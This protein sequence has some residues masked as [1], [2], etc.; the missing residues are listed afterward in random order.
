MTW[1]S[2]GV[3]CLPHEN[4][5]LVDSTPEHTVGVCKTVELRGTLAKCSL[6]SRVGNCAVAFSGHGNKVSNRDN[7][8]PSS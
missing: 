1:P 6:P 8:Q 2:H 7:P 3:G 4:L 5:W